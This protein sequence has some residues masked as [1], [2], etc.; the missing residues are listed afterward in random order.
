MHEEFEKMFGM[1]INI[2][3]SAKVNPVSF[4]PENVDVDWI[5][6]ETDEYSKCLPLSVQS[7]CITENAIPNN[8]WISI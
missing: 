8:L 6:S 1:P 4:A 2:G 3:D 5:I 7:K